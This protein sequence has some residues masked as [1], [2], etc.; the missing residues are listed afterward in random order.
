MRLFQRPSG[1]WYCEFVRNK[2]RSLGTK[3]KEQAEKVFEQ[4]KYQMQTDKAKEINPGNSGPVKLSNFKDWYLKQRKRSDVLPETVSMDELAIRRL[5]DF[6]GDIDL[7]AFSEIGPIEEFKRCGAKLGLSKST[8]NTYLRHIKVALRFAQERGLINE[9]AKIKFLKTP[10]RLPQI[11]AAAHLPNILDYAYTYHFEM[12]RI[13]KFAMWT[14][15]RRSE[16]LGVKYSD[17]G[18]LGDTYFINIIG[19]GD[20]QRMVMLLDGAMDAIV[21]NSYEDESEN[22]VGRTGLIFQ[23]YFKDSVSTIFKE[24]VRACGYEKYKFHNLRHSAGTQMLASGI[25]LPVV[26]K[27]LGHED[28]RTT[29]IYA[30]VVDQY[31]FSQMKKLSY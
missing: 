20:K 22:I 23:R 11:I 16:I 14:G 8:I 18:M 30:Q 31:M 1:V 28:I 29:Q 5:A 24:I 12:W 21:T 25:P 19:K 4:I 27:V 9:I 3:N 10:K 6:V 7:M 13:I 15:C 17:I 26:Q 2:V